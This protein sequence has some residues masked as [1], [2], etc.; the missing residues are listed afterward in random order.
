MRHL[1]LV[2]GAL[3]LLTGCPDKK[4]KDP[5]CA[6]DK[7]CKEG[8]KCVNKKCVI[9]EDEGCS[10]DGDCPD[11]QVCKNRECVAC[12]ADGECGEGGKCR[13]GKCIRKGQC[14]TDDDCPEDQDCVEGFCRASGAGTGTGT[15]PSCTL[16][17]IYFGFNEY[18]LNDEAKTTLEKN[19]SCLNQTTLGVFVI[20]RTD[21]RGTEEYNIGLSDDRA[22]SV[23]TYLGRMGIDPARL[24]KTPKGSLEA[25]GT[26]E[27]GWSKDRRVEL[28]W[29]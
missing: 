9:A 21:P 17:P 23:V 26:D 22:Q 1:V 2:L 10:G 11:G 5:T 16:E 12:Q 13:D 8:E 6:G 15:R 25:T 29:Q 18:T 3:V 24:T 7:D 4:P 28:S 27:T 14:E 19:V 20:G